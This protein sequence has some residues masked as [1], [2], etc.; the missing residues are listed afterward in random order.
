MLNV[1]RKET[2]M[3]L[4]ENNTNKETT[5]KSAGSVEQQTRMR[6]RQPQKQKTKVILYKT[7]Y[8][9]NQIKKILL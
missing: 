4:N 1:G 3:K 8:I 9:L 5:S 7:T 2:G 6:H